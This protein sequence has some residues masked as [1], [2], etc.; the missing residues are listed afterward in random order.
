MTYVQ[1]FLTPCPLANRDAYRAHAEGAASFFREFGATRLV[2]AWQDDVPSGRLNDFHGAVQRRE[3]EAVLFSW[4]EYPD[5]AT[6]RAAQG[7]IMSDPRMAQMP[8]MPF[9]GKRMM[10]GGFA[11]LIDEGAGGRPG[12]VD[13]FVLPVPEGGREAYVTMARKACGVFRD[14]GATRYVE[15][16]GDDV[17][18]GKVTDF[19][20]A[21]HAQDGEGVVFSWCE[22]PDKAARDAGMQAIMADERMKTAPEDMPFDGRRMIYGGFA[23]LVDTAGEAR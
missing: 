6:Y 10:F 4:I 8:P 7:R 3:D 21:A 9:D 12:Y 22:W 19:R 2:E 23:I 20:R 16:W 15:A 11:P 5:A 18:D 13:G 17:P 1:G 14:H